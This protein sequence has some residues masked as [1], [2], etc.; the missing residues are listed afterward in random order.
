MS[1]CSAGKKP[2][3]RTKVGSKAAQCSPTYGTYD[4]LA[5]GLPEEAWPE[6]PGKGVHNYTRH[7]GGVVIEVQLKNKAYRIKSFLSGQ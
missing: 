3:A 2:P 7:I 5:L 6:G 4:L 1:S